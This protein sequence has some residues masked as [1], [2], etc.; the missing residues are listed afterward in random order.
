MDVTETTLKNLNDE[1]LTVNLTVWARSET[2]SDAANQKVEVTL[3]R[4]G[5]PALT[6]LPTKVLVCNSTSL[7]C[8]R[9]ILVLVGGVVVLLSILNTEEE[10][11]E[12][13]NWGED[14]YEDSLS[15]TYGAV[16]GR[17][18]L[19]RCPRR[20]ALL[21]APPA[22][23]AAEPTVDFK[24]NGPPP[25]P[26]GGFLRDG[27]WSSGSTTVSSG[28]NKTNGEP[29]LLTMSKRRVQ[30]AR[31]LATM[32]EGKH[33]YGNGQAPIFILKDGTQRTAVVEP[34]NPT[35]SQ[36]PKLSPMPFAPRSVPKAWTKCW[37]IRWA[38][39]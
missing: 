35:T 31:N 24:A 5:Q 37:S 4:D 39:W 34:L 3:I 21:P 10:D 7:Q 20:T 11:D 2:V 19:P 28:W 22:P 13:A 6:P 23:V 8:G 9:F 38:T 16:S 14:G 1:S 29:F 17:P 32:P 36:Q 12:Y 26:E 33:M 18:Y 15:A 25:P 30:V 27:R